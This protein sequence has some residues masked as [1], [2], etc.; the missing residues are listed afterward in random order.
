MKIRILI[1]LAFG[2][3]PFFAASQTATFDRVRVRQGLTIRAEKADSIIRAI[4]A[5]SNHTSIPTAK[6]VWDAIAASVTAAKYQTFRDDGS[7]MTQQPNANFVSTGTVAFTLTNDAGN[8]ETKVSAAVP[9]GG[10]TSTEILDG[11][12]ANADVSSSA[13]IANSKLANSGVTAGT[14]PGTG[15]VFPQFTVNS[16]GILT[17]VIN[18]PLPDTSPSNEGTLGV[19]AGGP[20]NALLTSNTSGATGVTYAGGTAI[21]ISEITNTNGGT[22]TIT[23]T[24]DTDSAN[25]L[26][27]SDT[28]RTVSGA[29]THSKYPTAAAVW[30]AIT[31]GSGD[32]RNGGNTTGATVIIGTNDANALELE[33]GGTSKFKISTTGEA[34]QEATV[35]A[36]TTPAAPLTMQAYSTG[37]PGVGFGS[38][39]QFNGESTTTNNRSMG[40]IASTW[41]TATDASRVSNLVFTIGRAAGDTEVARMAQNRLTVGSGTLALT[42][43]GLD[44]GATTVSLS[45]TAVTGAVNASS[46]GWTATSGTKRLLAVEGDLTASSGTAALRAIAVEPFY[47]LSGTASGTQ[48]G[49]SVAPSFSGLGAGTFRGLDLSYNN[50]AAFGIYQSGA[51]S[52]N[53]FAGRVGIGTTSAAEALHTVGNIRA[54]GTVTARGTASEAIVKIS[55]TTPTTGRL[56]DII[57]G[58]DGDFLISQ[59]AIGVS[60]SVSGTTGDVNIADQLT[61]STLG[62]T[63]T[64]ILGLNASSA[65]SGITVGSGLTLSGDTL[66][67]TG[68]GGGGSDYLGTGFTSGGGSGTIPDATIAQLEDNFSFLSPDIAVGY[69]GYNLGNTPFIEDWKNFF[70]FFDNSQAH[71]FGMGYDAAEDDRLSMI[72]RFLSTDDVTSFQVKETRFNFTNFN[73]TGGACQIAGS[74]GALTMSQFDVGQ[75]TLGGGVARFSDNRGTPIGIEYDS[76][77]SATI[78]TNARSIPDVGTVRLLQKSETYNTITSTS[79]PQ[80]LEDG[81]NLLNQG[82]TQAT[83]T[84]NLPASPIDGELCLLTFNNAVTVLTISG[85][86]NSVVG[87][88]PTTAAIA[89]H[90]EFKF[91]TGIGWI[92]TK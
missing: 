11:T 17:N 57:S 20:N 77:Y 18:V 91:Y 47:D 35:S 19:G 33:T 34:T 56:W 39:L 55:N 68:G 73:T 60:L 24:G 36:T 86:G 63:P 90:F 46:W 54:D 21:G 37:T 13:N 81:D 69:D 40:N 65:V 80:V 23:N 27:L 72:G 28:V 22:I 7:N 88:L 45:S 59:S 49:I 51:N 43:S 92:R 4:T 83:F 14:Y 64:S 78:A 6:A 44:G 79:S 16:K 31:T 89:S 48:V 53:Y 42:N 50:T 82:G 2:L 1:L 3:L 58:D 8:T 71:Y 74:S 12:I 30:S 76:D 29:S 10:I 67:A 5:L 61:I 62:S 70:G 15:G 66:R 32:I 9:A 26:T 25:D 84:F 41:A 85:N 75:I 38:K 52:P 87:S